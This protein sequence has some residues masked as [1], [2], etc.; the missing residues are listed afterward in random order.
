M[1]EI[2]LFTFQAVADV[3]IITDNRISFL[4]EQKLAGNYRTKLD[5]A[6]PEVIDI[7]VINDWMRDSIKSKFD[8][9]YNGD[10]YK[11]N[12]DCTWGKADGFY[13][14]D[15]IYSH[16]LKEFVRIASLPSKIM[17]N[18]RMSED[19]TVQFCRRHWAT[20]INRNVVRFGF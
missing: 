17:A 5:L 13:P 10:N 9:A 20:R 16:N 7:Q 12:L 19:L 11:S 18:G 4:L 1:E 3:V 2:A 8:I 15:G 6:I 14:F